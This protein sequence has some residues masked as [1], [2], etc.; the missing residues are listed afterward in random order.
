MIADAWHTL[1]DTLTSI[2]VIVGFYIS[3]QPKDEEHPF[4]H[5][6]AE[7]IAAI[8]GKWLWWIDGFL[9]IIVSS[10]ILYTAFDVAKSAANSLLGEKM[11][12]GLEKKLYI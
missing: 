11:D 12:E 9:G 3:S 7:V 8:L 4:G 5:G 1:S 10:L 2:V 6:R